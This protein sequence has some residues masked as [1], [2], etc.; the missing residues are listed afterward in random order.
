MPCDSRSHVARVFSQ[1]KRFAEAAG[2]TF[3]GIGKYNLRQIGGS[4]RLRSINPEIQIM[5]GEPR[6]TIAQV[7]GHYLCCP[8]AFRRGLPLQANRIRW[9]EKNSGI[10]RQAMVFLFKKALPRSLTCAVK[11]VIRS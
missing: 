11:V 4:Y 8:P 5:S 6:E 1:V 9:R 7:G 3:A 2:N 10:D